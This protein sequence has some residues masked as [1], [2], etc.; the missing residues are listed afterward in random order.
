MFTVHIRDMGV[1]SMKI[2][3]SAL[4]DSLRKAYSAERAACFAYVGHAGSLKDPDE[5]K[6][7][8]QIEQDEWDH[9]AHVLTLMQQYDIP[10]SKWYELKFYL[11]GKFIG[12]SCYVIGW[13]MPYFF[14]GKLES[15]NV[16]EYFV[17]I[18]YFHSLGIEEHDE[19]LFEMGIKEKEHEVYFLETIKDA[20]WLPLFEKIFSWGKDTTLNDVDFENIPKVGESD[21]ICKN[22]KDK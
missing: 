1:R 14:A 17:M 18:H 11:I 12:Y 15:G 16:C 20:R 4:V 6:A 13:F 8:Q 3:H 7:V 5:I 22:F 10:I 9:R 21:R 19:I 2:D